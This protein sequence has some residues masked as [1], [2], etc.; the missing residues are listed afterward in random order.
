MIQCIEVELCG[1]QFFLFYN[2]EA[3]FQIQERFPEDAL[4]QISMNTKSA[5]D[6]SVVLFQLLAEQGELAR[7]NMGYD[8]RT[9]PELDKQRWKLTPADI[10]KMKNGIYCA[11]TLGCERKVESLEDMDLTLLE[12]KKKSEEKV[13]A[14]IT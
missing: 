1:E 9:L 6:L 7:R 10:V 3:M 12:I 11:I 2:V 4:D 14:S 8:S 13:S 5:L